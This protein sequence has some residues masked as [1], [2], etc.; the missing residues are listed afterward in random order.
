VF[1]GI[2]DFR[3]DAGHFIFL[4]IFYSVLAI[5]LTTMAIALRRAL[6]QF[7]SE[8]VD[9]LRWHADFDD[10]PSSV[11]RCRHELTGEI[12]TRECPNGFDCR[13]CE[14]HPEFLAARTAPLA[15]GEPLVAGFAVPE[16]RLYHR[17][18]TWVRP[19]LDGT[20]TIGLDDF[21]SRLAGK[22]KHLKLPAVGKRLQANGTG[23]R[24]RRYGLDVRI[25]APIDGE[26][27]ATGG[28]DEGWYLKVKPLPEGTDTR[29][30]LT[31]AEAKA[32][33]LRELE[34]LQITLTPETVG[35]T[36][37]DGGTPID[38]LSA[39]IPREKLDEVY[40]MVFLHP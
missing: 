26:V 6:G 34:R 13:H 17:G 30:L 32:W 4:G 21:A 35:A 2:Y 22:P 39:A 31:P 24:T 25:L 38:D 1:P 20:F 9:A 28:P 10:L 36:L 8:R 19:E 16:D 37:A 33:L 27:V 11:R 29:H 7:R 14:K 23:W 5:V 18:H 40:A 3:W 15:S 12:A